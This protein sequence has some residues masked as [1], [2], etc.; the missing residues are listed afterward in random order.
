MVEK[1]K[2]KMI[3]V[4]TRVAIVITERVEANSTLLE[5]LASFATLLVKSFNLFKVS[6]ARLNFVREAPF[7]LSTDSF[8]SLLRERTMISE[9]SLWYSFH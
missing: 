4:M 7:I 2:N 5:E 9:F 8:E 1:L 3:P 6:F